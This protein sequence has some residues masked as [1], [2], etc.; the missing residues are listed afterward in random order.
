MTH[1]CVRRYHRA[2][3]AFHL[4]TDPCL[5]ALY[6]ALNPFADDT[7]FY[8]ELAAS[9]GAAR[10]VDIGC[11][12]GILTCEL[13]MRGHEVTGIDPSP[14]MLAVARRRPGGDR[15]K[16]IEGD[17]SEADEQDADLAIMT[18]HV[19][20]VFV[21]DASWRATLRA[22]HRALRPGGCLAFESGNPAIK[23]W[24]SWTPDA[25]R[26]RVHSEEQGAVDVWQQLIDVDGE[27]VRFDNHYR[28]ER[29]GAEIV[30][31][32]ALHFR[33]QDALMRWY[34]DWSRTPVDATSRELIV[35]AVRD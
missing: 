16:W 28:F 2:M 3:T 26:R 7:V 24:V 21:D 33:T 35:V 8:L 19:A 32:S 12:T 17:A 20:Q 29:D 23:P 4:Y 6:D 9:R 13:A 30:S 5:V 22:A 15:V 1:A 34:G 14:V 10:I 18:G 31:P 11:G 25:S 27:R